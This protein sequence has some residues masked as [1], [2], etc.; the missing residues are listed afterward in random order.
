VS[1][2]D[3]G[4]FGSSWRMPSDGDLALALRGGQPRRRETDLVIA[5]TANVI[6]VTLMTDNVGDFEIIDDLVHAR[7]PEQL[8]HS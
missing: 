6:G 3:V 4:D 8:R 2:R 7:S 1:D 5:A